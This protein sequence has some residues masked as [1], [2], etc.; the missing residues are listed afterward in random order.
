M[1]PTAG[2]CMLGWQVQN[3]M[4][5]SGVAGKKY[6]YVVFK[7]LMQRNSQK[8]NKTKPKE[9]NDRKTSFFSPQ[10]FWQKV[11]TWTF[12]NELFCGVFELPSLR[13]AQ[14]R[15]FFFKVPT[16]LI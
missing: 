5:I 9:K 6:V 10:L 3:H 1:R 2:C 13:N 12:S 14:K 7:L 11:L 15:H 16:Y 8:R 4:S